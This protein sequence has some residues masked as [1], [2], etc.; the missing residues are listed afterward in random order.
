[1]KRNTKIKNIITYLLIV[2]LATLLVCM[3]YYENEQEKKETVR[4]QQLQEEQDAIQKATEESTM[5]TLFEDE[6]V[7]LLG[8]FQAVR[9]LSH[10]DISQCAS[11]VSGY[12]SN[13]SIKFDISDI[14]PK[15]DESKLYMLVFEAY[16]ESSCVKIAVQIAGDTSYY[17]LTSEPS[18]FYLP[19]NEINQ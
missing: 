3:L 14:M 7:N 19:I 16:S 9:I 1:M 5:L 4:L 13:A 10:T 6:S 17:Y 18:A 15:T 11:F 8:S 2:I 12:Y